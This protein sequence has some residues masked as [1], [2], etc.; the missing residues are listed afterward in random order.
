VPSVVRAPP[1]LVETMADMKFPPK[2][3]DRLTWLMDRNT[4]GQL[5]PTGRAT[6]EAFA[7]DSPRRCLIR[8]AESGFGLSPPEG[9]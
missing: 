1:S 2:T 5:T 3:D 7:F 4:E 9:D 6:V 8:A